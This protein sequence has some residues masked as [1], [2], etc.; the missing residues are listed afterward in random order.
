MSGNLNITVAVLDLFFLLN[1]NYS[2]P[3]IA[4]YL[5]RPSVTFFSITNPLAFPS[6][7][8]PQTPFPTPILLFILSYFLW[9]PKKE[10]FEGEMCVMRVAH[11]IFCNNP[12]ENPFF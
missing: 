3:Q 4:A 11:K 5:L 12:V 10:N 7:L 2:Q 1:G 8:P 6:P 9:K